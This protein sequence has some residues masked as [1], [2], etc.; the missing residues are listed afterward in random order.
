MSIY[1]LHYP[2]GD[3]IKKSEG[4]IIKLLD[5]NFHIPHLC[6]GGRFSYGDPL[7][8]YNNNWNS[9]RS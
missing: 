4:L 1:L 2:K 3:V 8:N 9:F 7:I 5:K 6:K